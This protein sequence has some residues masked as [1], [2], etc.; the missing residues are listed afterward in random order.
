MN[1]TRL[2]WTALALAAFSLP[3]TAQVFKL[4]FD[5]ENNAGIAL[6]VAP[7]DLPPGTSQTFGPAILG[8]YNDDPGY[9]RAGRQSWNTTF[10]SNANAIRSEEAGGPGNFPTA[11]SG[12]YAV[13]TIGAPSFEFAVSA[14]RVITGLSFWYNA[15]GSGVNP[16]VTVY[17]GGNS[18]FALGLDVAC[19]GGFC[20]WTNFE[21]PSASLAGKQVTRVQFSGT[22]NTLV[23]D[24]ISVNAVPI[25]EPSTY[26][27]MALGLATIGSIRRRR[28]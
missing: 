27:L 8:Y 21:V 24:D 16:A 25:P 19:S 18:L 10:S 3:A 7:P 11:K 15:D 1:M 22:P 12:S 28:R 26:A 20:G 6:A 4:D 17:S 13:G 14:G 5:G 23:F 9:Q 2:A